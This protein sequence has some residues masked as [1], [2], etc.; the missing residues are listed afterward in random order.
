MI[1][2]RWDLPNDPPLG[3]S[4]CPLVFMIP[5]AAMRDLDGNGPSYPT[6]D[7]LR[8]LSA[9]LNRAGFATFRYASSDG[10]SALPLGGVAALLARAIESPRLYRAHLVLLGIAEGAD[11]IAREYY[12]LYKVRFPHAAV[13]LSPSVFAFH[14]N[15]LTC[16]YLV[17]HG[18]DDSFY[19][20]A[21]YGRVIGAV[22]HHQMRFG[23]RTAHHL[24]RHLGKTLGGNRLS[25]EVLSG[26]VNWLNDASYEGLRPQ[27]PPPKAA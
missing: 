21:A 27:E 14:L 8:D 22:H 20:P 10:A 25:R 4:T 3:H 26:I 16:P 5:A 18:R 2:T 1:Q 17:L 7:S 6:K 13:L 11:L 9:E 24:Y 15:N 12:Q 23:D 19:E